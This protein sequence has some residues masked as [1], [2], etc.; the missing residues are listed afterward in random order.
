V[1]CAC[2]EHVPRLHVSVRT[3][4]LIQKL[5]KYPYTQ[6][7]Y[8]K[9]RLLPLVACLFVQAYEKQ[10][11]SNRTEDDWPPHRNSPH[12]IPEPWSLG[13]FPTFRMLAYLYSELRKPRLR[14][15]DQRNEVAE[16]V[17]GEPKS[18]VRPYAY[19]FEARRGHVARCSGL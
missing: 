18:L 11:A 7:T 12:G 9:S 14:T 2:T 5:S 19:L 4:S 16:Q 17:R 13:T 10:I 8:Q 6:Y 3:R 1:V 15:A